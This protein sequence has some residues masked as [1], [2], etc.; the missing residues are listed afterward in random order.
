MSKYYRYYKIA[1]YLKANYPFDFPVVVRR[2]KMP[3]N[4][5]GEC[6]FESGQY[7]ISINKKLSVDAAIET[8]LHEMAHAKS[9]GK[10]NEDHGINWGKE[11]SKIYRVYEKK[12]LT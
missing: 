7:F 9:W 11:Y 8:L 6:D 2:I 5:C 12:F 4:Y 3:E 10:D 1:R